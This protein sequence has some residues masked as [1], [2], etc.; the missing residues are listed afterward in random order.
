M[1]RILTDTSL[2]TRWSEGILEHGFTAVPNL[3]LI[4]RGQLNITAPEF[5]VLV[6]IDSFRWGAK[7][8]WPSLE[9][10]S[11]R[12]SYSRRTISKCVSSLEK[13]GLI[14]RIRRSNTSN[15]YSLEP[16]VKV[17]NMAAASSSY[18]KA[19]Q[20]TGE[21]IDMTDENTLSPKEEA[22]NNKNLK[23][24]TKNIVHVAE[25]R[26]WTGERWVYEV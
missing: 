20:P 24:P 19:H 16:L 5:V 17:L 2:A 8:P 11:E 21:I 22:I 10:L 6:A 12:C 25:K 18:R 3:L 9:A 14:E 15:Q 7:D 1:K 26:Y 13:K 4:Y 23:I